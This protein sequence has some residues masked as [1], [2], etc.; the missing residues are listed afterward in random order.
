MTLLSR[1]HLDLVMENKVVDEHIV[2]FLLR[3]INTMSTQHTLH[4][5]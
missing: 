1:H 5:F 3:E 4:M 2:I